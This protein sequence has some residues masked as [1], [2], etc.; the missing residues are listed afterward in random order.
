MKKNE[1]LGIVMIIMAFILTTIYC[2]IA[3]YWTNNA[4]AGWGWGLW[5]LITGFLGIGT[6]SYFNA[7]TKN[8]YED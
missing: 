1:I 8:N 3:V 5:F 2:F 4:D 7:Y 6:A